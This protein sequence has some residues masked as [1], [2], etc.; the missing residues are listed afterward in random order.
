MKENARP[1]VM[2][3]AIPPC[4]CLSLYTNLEN[5]LSY[6]F[7]LIKN[8]KEQKEHEQKLSIGKCGLSGK[9]RNLF[10]AFLALC[11]IKQLLVLKK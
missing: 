6:K 8:K 1:T 4:Y 3:L 2:L 7:A 5:N 11:I 10:C 9:H